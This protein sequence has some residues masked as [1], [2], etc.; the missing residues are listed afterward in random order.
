[1]PHNKKLYSIINMLWSCL[2]DFKFFACVHSLC[3]GLRLHQILWYWWN[4]GFAGCLQ[5]ELTRGYGTN[6][7]HEDLKRLLIQAKHLSWGARH[8]IDFTELFCFMR[9]LIRKAYDSELKIF[10]CDGVETCTWFQV[11]DLD[12]IWTC[13]L[14]QMVNRPFS[15]LLTHRSNSCVFRASNKKNSD[16]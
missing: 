12:W 7:F 1:M 6:E 9:S 2:L 14:G 5:I 4:H 8:E 10:C 16:V 15:S 11:Q 13:R 3:F